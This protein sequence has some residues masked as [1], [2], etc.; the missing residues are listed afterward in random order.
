MPT[1][2]PFQARSS[3]DRTVVTVANPAPVAQ[4]FPQPVAYPPHLALH[5]T[6]TVPNPVPTVQL[7]RAG[8]TNHSHVHGHYPA[9][10]TAVVAA[11]PVP[12]YPHAATVVTQYGATPASVFVPGSYAAS[13]TMFGGG[14]R[15]Q[16]AHQVHG[17][18]A[19]PTHHHQGPGY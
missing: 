19:Q 5:T 11:N 2:L 8:G 3:A 18:G 4:Q 16:P 10:P 14:F 17:H 12:V 13:Q 9:A 1:H 15:A 6:V 7:W